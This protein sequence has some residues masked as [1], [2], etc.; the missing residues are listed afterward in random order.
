MLALGC[1]SPFLARPLGVD[2][3]IYP[4]KGYSMTIPIGNHRAPPT[5]AALDEDNLVAISRFGDRIRV[6]A[7]AEFAGYDISHMPADFAH[8]TR[9]RGICIRMART[10]RGPRCGPGCGR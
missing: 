3:P 2:L 4:I 1:Q 10:T 5:M 7:T 8:M 9:W 6:T